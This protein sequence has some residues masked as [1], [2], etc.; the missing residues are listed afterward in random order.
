MCNVTKCKTNRYKRTRWLT[1]V[2]LSV[3]LNLLIFICQES[4]QNI[5]KTT[6]IGQIQNRDFFFYSYI[7]FYFIAI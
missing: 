1:L 6:Q 5:Y 4:V 3:K 7:Y 2:G